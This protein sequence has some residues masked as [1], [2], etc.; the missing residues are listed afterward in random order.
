MTVWWTIVYVESPHQTDDADS[1]W[2]IRPNGDVA[3]LGED[4]KVDWEN[5]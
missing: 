3:R 5:Y 2:T 1:L 4:H